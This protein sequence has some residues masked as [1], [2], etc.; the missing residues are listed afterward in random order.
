ML[1]RIVA[2]CFSL[3]AAAVAIYI[4]VR[5]IQSVAGALVA[6]TAVAGGLII[7]GLI[8]RLLWRHRRMNRW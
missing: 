4:A 1:D 7:L 8:A 3:L 6:I 2:I 5:L